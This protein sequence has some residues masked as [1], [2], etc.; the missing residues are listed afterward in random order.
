MNLNQRQT[1]STHNTNRH[2][3]I[4]FYAFVG[5]PLWKQLYASQVKPREKGSLSNYLLASLFFVNVVQFPLK[6]QQA[7]SG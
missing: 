5:Q 7:E 2:C 1:R 4:R 3:R 6:D